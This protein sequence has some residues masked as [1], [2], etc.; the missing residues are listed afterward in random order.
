MDQHVEPPGKVIVPEKF[1]TSYFALHM[2][3]RPFLFLCALSRLVLDLSNKGLRVTVRDGNRITDTNVKAVCMKGKQVVWGGM[4][5]QSFSAS[6]Q[7]EGTSPRYPATKIQLISR[8][9]TLISARTLL[10]VANYAGPP[11]KLLVPRQE[12]QTGPAR[13]TPPSAVPSNT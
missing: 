8:K 10:Y 2:K 1:S 3:A 6:L 11:D 12:G 13:P 5:W 7:V 9:K 4:L